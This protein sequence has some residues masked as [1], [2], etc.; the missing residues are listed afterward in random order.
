M[1]SVSFNISINYDNILE[2]DE[3]FVLTINPS[4]SHVTVGNFSHTTV[5]IVDNDSKL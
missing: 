5:T 1:T 3:Y 2:C 4:S